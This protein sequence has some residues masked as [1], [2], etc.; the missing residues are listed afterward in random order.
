MTTLQNKVAFVMGASGGIGEAVAIA[1]A[2]RGAFISL[3]SRRVDKLEG[4][5][6]QIRS[7]GGKA[8]VL[9]TDL[10]Y[11]EQISYAFEKS[12]DY[13]H[14]LDVLINSAAVGI[15]S[16]IHNGA[17]EN[18]REMVDV[19]F[20]SV[21]ISMREALQYFHST[22]GGHIIN[23]SSTSAHRIPSNGGFYATTK[24]AIHSLTE[25]FR[26]E[27]RARKSPVRI[28]SV[29]PGRVS[30]NLFKAKKSESARKR[31]SR[32][33]STELRPE[34]IAKI[35]IQILELPIEVEVN[36]I[37]IRARDSTR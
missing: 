32:R 1:L 34:D 28:T 33:E 24:F 23:I 20:L 26:N 4:I 21:A 3:V 8:L 13:W 16:S 19:N 37:I 11:Q 18:W 30:T 12:N 2:D 36:D 5:A 9:P 6:N 14:R 10:R 22:S 7:K 17:V 35:I 15:E 25:V 27:L 31:S 29:S